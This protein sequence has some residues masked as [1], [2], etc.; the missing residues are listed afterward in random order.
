VTD[1]A[2]GI[3][4]RREFA[5][6]YPNPMWADGDLI[7]SLLLFFDGVALLVPAYM[8]DLPRRL[9]PAIAGAMEDQGLLKLVMPESAVDK[10]AAQKLGSVIVDLLA[11]GALNELSLDTSTAFA[12]ISWSRLGAG[13]DRRL[14]EEIV[15][16]LKER[17]LAKDS[18]DGVSVPLHPMVRSLI[19]I[20]LSQLLRGAT[21]DEGI[22]LWPATDRPE[23]VHALQ[24][25]LGTAPLPSA[26]HVVTAD[27]QSIGVDV[28][29]VPLDELLDYRSREGRPWAK[30]M[31]DVRSFVQVVGQLPPDERH[32]AAADRDAELADAIADLRRNA[33]KE[34]LR[35][36]GIAIGATGS[37]W[38]A[39]SG[40]PL[41]A[42]ITAV[43]IGLQAAGGAI[44]SPPLGAFSYV[45]DVHARWPK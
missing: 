21:R 39:V 40:D 34:W 14:A 45:L 7:K 1:G 11:S 25:L 20:L 3:L 9:D 41:G 28:S 10:T 12:E 16:L 37:A 4:L 17:G 19:L 29:S 5:F 23:L 13:A 22:E 27:I 43:G 26:A 24:E 33:P 42:L 30:Y 18:D 36:A 38:Q 32:Q 35:P 2:D 8:T 31:R 6:Y 15:E 44:A